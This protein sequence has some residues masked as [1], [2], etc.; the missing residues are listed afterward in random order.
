MAVHAERQALLNAARYGLC[1]ERAI[2][3]SDMGVP[4]KDCML[5]IIS[6]GVAEIVCKE[7]TYYDA[8]SEHILNEWVSKGGKFRVLGET[9]V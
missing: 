4:C 6:A 5:E 8:S 7:E 3:Y 9:G 1:T 2:L